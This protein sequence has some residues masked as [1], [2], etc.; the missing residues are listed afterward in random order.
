MRRRALLACGAVAALG[1]GSR[2]S[3][4]GLVAASAERRVLAPTRFGWVSSR[5][6]SGPLPSAIALGGEASGSVALF[7]EFEELSQPRLLRAVLRLDTAGPPGGDADVKVSRAEA[8][9]AEL[10]AWS[11][12]PR[13]LDPWLS[14]RL[15]TD[16]SPARIDVTELARAANQ[17]GEPA[18]PLRLLLWAEPSRVEPVLVQT[19]AAGGT[20]PRLEVYWE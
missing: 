14:A 8:A 16:A 19:G 13:A 20:G 6:A 17:P 5:Q 3:V 18:G 9:H 10:R 12:Q 4:G 1:C 15:S 2:S 11:D 7:L